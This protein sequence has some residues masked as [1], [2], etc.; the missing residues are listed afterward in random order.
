M[1]WSSP[2]EQALTLVCEHLLCSSESKREGIFISVKDFLFT[3]L[4]TGWENESWLTEEG[5]TAVT[6][7]GDEHLDKNL[8]LALIGEML[9]IGPRIAIL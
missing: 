7:F 5:V 6:V 2:Q 4:W 8:N 1:V 9:D 3:P